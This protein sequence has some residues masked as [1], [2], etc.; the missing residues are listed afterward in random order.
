MSATHIGLPALPE[1][2]ADCPVREILDRV[3]DEWSVL[4]IDQ[5]H[6]RRP[7]VPDQRLRPAADRVHLSER[8]AARRGHASRPARRGADRLAWP[9]CSACYQGGV[10]GGFSVVR[11]W[12]AQEPPMAGR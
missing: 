6:V 7:G 10:P 3:G 11:F 4:V 9:G 5:R 12:V 8:G 2:V 1:V